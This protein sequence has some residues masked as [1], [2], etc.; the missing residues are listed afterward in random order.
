MPVCLV[1]YIID[2]NSYWVATDRFDISAEQVALI[3]K[4]RWDLESFFVCWKQT[5]KCITF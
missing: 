5:L 1:G 4:L 3:G 2:G